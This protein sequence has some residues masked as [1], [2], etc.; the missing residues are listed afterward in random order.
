MINRERMIAIKEIGSL[1]LE[2]NN[3]KDIYINFFL[4]ID[5]EISEGEDDTHKFGSIN[6]FGIR[7]SVEHSGKMYEINTKHAY[8]VVDA[9]KIDYFYI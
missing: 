5:S 9:L 7:F 2:E 4:R 6:S 8:K 1:N 3:R